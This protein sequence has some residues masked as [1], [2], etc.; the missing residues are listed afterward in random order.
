MR[1]LSAAIAVFAVVAGLSA[2][3]AV[4]TPGQPPVF[5]APPLFN[6]APHRPPPSLVFTY[7]GFQVDASHGAKGVGPDRTVRQI[8]AQIDLV[9]KLGLK[10]EVLAAMRTVPIQA[11]PMKLGESARYV[12]GQGVLIKVA[13]LAPKKPVLLSGLLEAYHDQKLAA[14]P[15]QADIARFR[16]EAMARHVWPKTAQMLQSDSDYFALTGSAYLYGAITREP[17]TRANLRQT[18]PAYYQWLAGFFD[19]GHARG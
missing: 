9:Q 17:Y 4:A 6:L 11:D 18:Q 19:A 15:G 13:K 12:R 7:Q 8:K 1:R 3:P 2:S 14:G 10:P 16:N 5:V